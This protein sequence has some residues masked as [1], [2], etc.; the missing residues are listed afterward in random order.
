MSRLG[1][2]SSMAGGRG[3]REGGKEGG[4]EGGRKEI[5]RENGWMDP[6]AVSHFLLSVLHLFLFLSFFLPCLPRSFVHAYHTY[7]TGVICSQTPTARQ[8]G[9]TITIARLFEPLP[10]RRAEFKR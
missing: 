3:G 2:E 9:T 7:S 4:R 1:P 5:G 10:V 6:G 8:P